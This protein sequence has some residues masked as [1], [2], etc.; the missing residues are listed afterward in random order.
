MTHIGFGF[1]SSTVVIEGP[2]GIPLDEPNKSDRGGRLE[3]VEESGEAPGLL[4]PVRVHGNEEVSSPSRAGF[5]TS[6][7][8]QDRGS[9]PGAYHRGTASGEE[10]LPEAPGS[11]SG[12]F[13]ATA[14]VIAD[15]GSALDAD[16][17]GRIA[18]AAVLENEIR[19]N[20]AVFSETSAVT[21]RERGE[22]REPG[23]EEQSHVAQNEDCGSSSAV[24]N[25][26]RIA[27]GFS[28][29]SSSCNAGLSEEK[30]RPPQSEE[31]AGASTGTSAG[32]SAGASAGAS[33]G[34]AT[35]RSGSPEQSETGAREPLPE[36]SPEVKAVWEKTKRFLW[37]K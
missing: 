20:G 29:E 26:E 9:E 5:S 31:S 14:G 33:T 7:A 34:A 30:A 24:E 10:G 4:K 8:V 6:K 27:D 11:V 12:A 1:N 13:V 23:K 15:V 2:E 3:A 21:Q 37:Q 32:T 18:S 35:G 17:I 22:E 36:C 28:S 16:V 19:L 25:A